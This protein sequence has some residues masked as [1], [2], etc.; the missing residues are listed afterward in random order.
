MRKALGPGSM[1]KILVVSADFNFSTLLEARLQMDGYQ[2]FLAGD[3]VLGFQ[4]AREW[5]PKLIILDAALPKM[6]GYQLVE[7]LKTPG[8]PLR[9]IPIIVVADR[10]RMQHLFQDA[11][12][13]YFCS[14]PIIPALFLKQVAEAV[15]S[16]GISRQAPLKNLSGGKRVLLMGV[17]E[18]IIAKMKK[19]FEQKE[20]VVDIGWDGDDLIQKAVKLKPDYIFI[21]FWEEV[22][23]LDTPK[24]VKRLKRH[25]ELRLVPVFAFCSRNVVRDAVFLLPSTKV[26]GFYESRDLLLEVERVLAE[27]RTSVPGERSSTS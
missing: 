5:E 17:Q 13:F 9:S 15:K 7:R 16:V 26:I 19:F 25:E 23:I 27:G 20:F 4:K 22:S 18:F 11:D 6:S 1:E 24:I 12:I 21:Q 2:V 10:A 14:K 8:D 3:G